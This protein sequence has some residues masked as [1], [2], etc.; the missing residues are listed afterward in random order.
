M[1]Y[2]A[3]PDLDSEAVRRHLKATGFS[4]GLAAVFAPDVLVHAG[5]AR[6]GA[7]VAE[8]RRGIVQLIE[9]F[10]Q[11]DWRAQRDEAE[12][13][14]GDDPTEENWSRLQQSMLTLH[15]HHSDAGAP[16]RREHETMTQAE[17]HSEG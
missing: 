1:L 6:G 12:R 13:A 11:A 15:Q 10:R 9:R 3:N 5:F 16:D 2:A 8:A 7:D 17:M 14:Y 4:D